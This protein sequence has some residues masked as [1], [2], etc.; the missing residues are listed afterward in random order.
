MK[1]SP[2]LRKEDIFTMAETRKPNKLYC[3][4]P[5]NYGKGS[6]ACRVTG[7]DGGMGLIR[8][9]GINMKRQ[10]FRERATDMGWIKY[11]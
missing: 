6:R 9:Y 11:S 4:H 3:T 1:S 10:V 2:S 7:R 8:K 5:K